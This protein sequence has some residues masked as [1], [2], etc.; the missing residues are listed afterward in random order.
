[1]IGRF[2][3]HLPNST[4]AKLF[5]DCSM[6]FVRSGT[7]FLKKQRTKGH[8]AL[9]S[10][11]SMKFAIFTSP[12]IKLPKL[13][14]PRSPLPPTILTTSCS[15]HRRIHFATS[16]VIAQT[17]PP[18][19]LLLIPLFTLF[20]SNLVIH[21]MPHLT[22]SLLAVAPFYVWQRKQ[23]SSQDRLGRLTRRRLVN[24]ERALKPHQPLNPPYQSTSPHF[25]QIHHRQV[26]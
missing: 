17:R 14:R 13:P 16:L 2:W 8:S 3:R 19:L 18:A 21:P 23:T 25:P 24:S 6:T 22:S 7:K 10:I 20:P 11:F 15:T 9:L 5:L 1:V 4:Y 26:P 12:Y